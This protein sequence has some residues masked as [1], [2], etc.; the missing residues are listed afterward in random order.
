MNDTTHP[1]VRIQALGFPWTTIDPFLFCAYHDDA[2]PRGNAQMGPDAPLAGRDLGQDFSRKDG[3]SMYHGHPVPGFPGHP[4]RGFETVTIVRKG[5]I[6]HADSLGAAARFGG[7]DVQWVTAGKGIVHSEMFPLLD[8]SSANPLELF[9][10]WLNLPARNKLAEP[11]FTMFW[12]EDVPHFTATD[13]DGRST[14]VASVAGRVGPIDGAPGAGGPLAP[15]PDSW[16]AA[17]DADVAI[18][19]VRMAPSAR[20]TLPAARGAGTRR[21]LYFFKGSSVTV[22]GQAVDRHAAIELRADAE[23]ELVNGETEGEFLVLQGRPIGEPVAQYGPFVMNTQA[24]IAQA[25]TDYRSTQFGGWPWPDPAPVHGRDPA[26]FARHPDG[27]EERPAAP[28]AAGA[29]ARSADTADTETIAGT[30]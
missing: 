22:A 6:D 11:H 27:R 13:A 26:R 8:G 7:G 9:Q 29:Q 4:H 16:A 1:I 20:W 2:Y 18:W 14:D 28:T 21:S 12:S 24:E 17:A 30:K 19:T 25:M 3:W 5:L 10:I 23:V 15:P